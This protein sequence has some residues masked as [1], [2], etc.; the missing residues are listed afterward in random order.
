MVTPFPHSQRW[1]FRMLKGL[2]DALPHFPSWLHPTQ[3]SPRIW[4]QWLLSVPWTHQTYFCLRWF[5][6][7]PWWLPPSGVLFSQYI[8][9]PSRLCSD[10]T[11]SQCS[12]LVT[13]F[14][15]ASPTYTGMPIIPLPCSP[16]HP[17]EYIHFCLL[18][19]YFLFLV[20]CLS[21]CIRMPISQVRDSCQLSFTNVSQEPRIV[22]GM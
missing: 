2:P 6:P 21:C 13:L 3:L 12:T 19:S 16:P 8:L 20:S 17:P 4:P 7:L 15:V 5:L 18:S 1:Q 14:K 22:S 10:V 11:F 9:S